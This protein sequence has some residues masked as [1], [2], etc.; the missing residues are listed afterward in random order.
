[1]FFSVIYIKSFYIKQFAPLMQYSTMYF[2]IIS[3][4]FKL[5]HEHNIIS[6]PLIVDCSHWD[7]H[8]WIADSWKLQPVHLIVYLHVFIFLI[9][10]IWLL[11]CREVLYCIMKPVF[12]AGRRSLFGFNNKNTVSDKTR[13]SF[14]ESCIKLYPQCKTFT[15]Y[16]L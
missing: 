13:Q 2:C 16:R 7:M 12:I 8:C 6:R 3:N 11:Q 15:V 5:Q 9:G 14:Q 4:N 1:M 10:Y